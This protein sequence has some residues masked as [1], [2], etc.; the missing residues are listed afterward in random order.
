[1]FTQE[2]KERHTQFT[3]NLLN[4]YECEDDHFLDHIT[5]SDDTWCHHYELESKRQSMEWRREFPNEEKVH[6][7]ALSG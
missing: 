6:D 2:Q 7:A 5:T 1:M 4:Q 3:Q